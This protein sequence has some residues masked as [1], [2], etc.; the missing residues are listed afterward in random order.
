MAENEAPKEMQGLGPGLVDQGSSGFRGSGFKVSGVSDS[1]NAAEEE[2]QKIKK[3]LTLSP[4][5]AT[6]ISP[7]QDVYRV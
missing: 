7:C 6:V 1:S 3:A 5:Q 4:R 2:A